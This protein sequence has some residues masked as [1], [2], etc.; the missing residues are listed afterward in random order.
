MSDILNEYKQ[1]VGSP[2][3]RW[4]ARTPPQRRTIEGR[5]CRLEP[6]DAARH[7][8][9]LYSAYCQAGDDRDWTYMVMGPFADEDSYRC[10]L[11]GAAASSDPL[12]YAVI[13]RRSGRAVGTLALMRIDLKNGVVEVGTV[14]FSPALKRTP[15]S[16]EAQYLLMRYVFEDLGYRRYE[17]K[18]DSLNEPSRKAAARL[19][20]QYEGMFRQAL[21]YK[22]R[23][24]DT[25][26]FSIIDSEWPA[27]RTAFEAWLAPENFDQH[28]AQRL[29]LS[30]MRAASGPGA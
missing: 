1:A 11:D 27:L 29:A 2:V 28:G 8:S 7:T 4:Q 14:M 3:P 20:F 17:W 21:V 25:A 9:D 13:D 24:R 6:L 30:A 16:T 19:G 23:N 12:H 15:I 26:W 5:Y 22:G 10:Y 18:C